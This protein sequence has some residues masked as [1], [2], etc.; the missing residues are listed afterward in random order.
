MKNYKNLR[1]LILLLLNT[2][3][4]LAKGQQND[5]YNSLMISQ[6]DIVITGTKAS[7]KDTI[8]LGEPAFLKKLGT[9]VKKLIE[10]AETEDTIMTHHIYQ[11]ADTWF[12]RKRLESITLTSAKYSV[13]FL[14]GSSLKVGD[15][16]STVKKM[17]PLSWANRQGKQV[18]VFLQSGKIIVDVNLIFE[19]DDQTKLITE[20]SC[21]SNNS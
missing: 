19:F 5:Q 20:I 18:F 1:L 3:G 15:H 12:L 8:L 16:I 4:F 7:S 17:F 9:P 2:S 13:K 21:E 14:N 6:F 10:Y 11:G